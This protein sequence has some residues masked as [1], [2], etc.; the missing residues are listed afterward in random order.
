VYAK[1]FAQSIFLFEKIPS[2]CIFMQKTF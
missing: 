1:W 2:L